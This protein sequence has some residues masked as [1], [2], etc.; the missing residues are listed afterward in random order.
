MI[1]LK[2][3]HAEGTMGGRIENNAWGEPFE[4]LLYDDLL[5]E[6]MNM[7]SLAINIVPGESRED[8][9]VYVTK[10]EEE[11]PDLKDLVVFEL[12]ENDCMELMMR[13][14]NIRFESGAD[15]HL[16]DLPHRQD[17]AHDCCSL[18]DVIEESG[19][20][21]DRRF[22]DWCAGKY[23]D[24]QALEHVEGSMVPAYGD[25][26]EDRLEW[27]KQV[28]AYL[29]RLEDGDAPHLDRDYPRSM[30]VPRICEPIMERKSTT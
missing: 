18:E 15:R 21:W 29:N 6:Q 20:E 22:W 1:S 14:G 24:L 7:Q 28:K 12:K 2:S 27:M 5:L 23:K 19:F 8:S 17:V 16:K 9:H 3:F 26:D 25:S 4:S 11:R 30:L 10:I 13:G